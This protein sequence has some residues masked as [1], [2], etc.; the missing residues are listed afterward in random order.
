MVKKSETAN[1]KDE[2]EATRDLYYTSPAS[3]KKVN[4]ATCIITCFVAAAIGIVIGLSYDDMSVYFGGTKSASSRVDFSRLS[5]VYDELYASF[6]GDID[7]E[8]VLQEAKRGLV[9]AAGDT[10]TY[11]MTAEEAAEFEK[12]LSGDVGAGIGVE[13]A[14]RNG[15]VTV[16]RTTENNPARKAGVL[17]GD[18]IY[19]ADDEDIFV[20]SDDEREAKPLETNERVE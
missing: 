9:K 16:M 2:I 3:T 7:E 1:K 8:K 20:L 15:Y 5:E 13:I 11:Y 19:K 10:Y 6:D 18:I 14:Q 12:D 4:L 17:A